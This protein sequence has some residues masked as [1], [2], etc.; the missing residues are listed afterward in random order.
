[1]SQSHAV[2]AAVVNHE[3][4]V[5]KRKAAVA[6]A[7]DIRYWN[8]CRKQDLMKAC[9]QSARSQLKTSKSLAK[10]W[11]ELSDKLKM[12]KN[13]DT[14]LDNISEIV[15]PDIVNDSIVD[16]KHVH[17][18][19][20]GHFTLSASAELT[21]PKQDEHQAHHDIRV[22]S[23]AQDDKYLSDGMTASMQSLVDGLMV[24]GG[25][26]IDPQDEAQLPNDMTMHIAMEESDIVSTGDDETI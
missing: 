21:Y 3:A 4:F 7:H 23:D 1:M 10:S 12:V 26:F 8:S 25:R 13:D 5:A 18:S 20:R 24:W 2:H 22:I 16:D 9:L 19:D 17:I 14:I 6:L 15:T 11:R